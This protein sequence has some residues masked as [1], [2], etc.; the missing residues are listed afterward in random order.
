[1]GYGLGNLHTGF[2][3]AGFNNLMLLISKIIVLSSNV[4]KVILCIILYRNQLK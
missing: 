4:L 2:N 1:M 3:K